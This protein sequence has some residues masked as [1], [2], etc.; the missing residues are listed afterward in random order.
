MSKIEDVLVMQ[1]VEIEVEIPLTEEMGE[2]RGAKLA[3]MG[4]D[5]LMTSAPTFLRPRSCGTSPNIARLSMAR[6]SLH[7]QLDAMILKRMAVLNGS[8]A[9]ARADTRAPQAKCITRN[10]PTAG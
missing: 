2:D 10:M 5:L 8:R 6:L 1:K 3:A 9:S 7:A 4:R